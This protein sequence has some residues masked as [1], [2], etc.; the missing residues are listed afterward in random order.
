MNN[1]KEKQRLNKEYGMIYSDTD[2]VKVTKRKY[3]IGHWLCWIMSASIFVSVI[4][5]LIIVFLIFRF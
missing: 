2:S 4:E 5:F 1:I 3:T